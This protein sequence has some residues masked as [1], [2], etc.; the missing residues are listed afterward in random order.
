MKR[1]I[2]FIIFLFIT[3]I[4]ICADDNNLQNIRVNVIE[5]FNYDNP[6]LIY[7]VELNDKSDLKIYSTRDSF[8]GEYAFLLKYSLDSDNMWG[9]KVFIY[10]NFD[11]PLTLGN[12]IKG[13][14]MI[15]GDGTMNTFA[16]QLIDVDD[17]VYTFESPDTL[18]NNNWHELIFTRDSFILDSDSPIVDK[19]LSNKIKG[20]RFIISNPF[21]DNGSGKIYLDNMRLFYNE[22]N[23]KNREKE[24]NISKKAAERIFKNS[25]ID[26]EYRN[27][28]RYRSPGTAHYTTTFSKG[29]LM[30]LSFYLNT[31][32]RFNNFLVTG[33][34]GFRGRDFSLAN[35]EWGSYDLFGK[36]LKLIINT[37]EF[38]KFVNTIQIGEIKPSFNRI[39]FYD[40]G[41]YKWEGIS[42]SGKFF[43][44]KGYDETGYNF[45][46]VKGW[47]TSKTIGFKHWY[48][49]FDF[50]INL[51]G[52]LFSDN[53]LLRKND[54]VF[55]SKRVIEDN[56]F[57][58]ELVRG[59]NL[60]INNSFAVLWLNY[61]YHTYNRYGKIYISDG[62]NNLTELT[63]EDQIIGEDV[64]L[65]SLTFQKDSENN[66]LYEK[67]DTPV[68]KKNNLA[69]LR[70]RIKGLPFSFLQE[71]LEFKYIEP[72]F[73]P[74][75]SYR[76]YLVSEKSGSIELLSQLNN[77]K[78][79]GNWI[80]GV[81]FKFAN[82]TLS[83]TNPYYFKD[84]KEFDWNIGKQIGNV[85]IN[86]KQAYL[87]FKN[88]NSI[89]DR[90]NS[91]WLYN[92]IILSFKFTRSTIANVTL[93]DISKRL[94]ETGKSDITYYGTQFKFNFKLYFTESSLL[95]IDYI[96]TNPPDSELFQNQWEL[97]NLIK[98]LLHIDFK[99]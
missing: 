9:S 22:N 76:T 71:I 12:F 83:D 23:F 43:P 66:P 11:T 85:S 54:Y 38:L 39:T 28:N 47:D 97:D 60:K 61:G 15:K 19:K 3:K 41:E 27:I 8:E 16:I 30:W 59:F 34:I 13:S 65:S 37:S 46:Y 74:F 5:N 45:F 64:D 75:Y 72:Y 93:G 42:I 29:D 86:Y 14:I 10:R 49:L 78:F 53:A 50:K 91:R 92:F 4:G 79:I 62:N 94:Y 98:L 68:S 2:V 20:I 82:S 87:W 55:K 32:Y 81:K 73:K 31:E 88:P 51:Y 18:A 70:L 69:T 95:Q 57:A 33:L 63:N 48:K 90:L 1:F 25:Y 35:S 52:V 40:S 96:K 24:E 89:Y 17:E 77:Y 44:R 6:S 36:D 84:L 21:S 99:F 7:K 26:F 67:L 56:I 58:I 80:L